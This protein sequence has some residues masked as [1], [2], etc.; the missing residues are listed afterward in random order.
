LNLNARQQYGPHVIVAVGLG[1]LVAPVVLPPLS[2]GDPTFVYRAN[3]VAATGDGVRIEG[4]SLDAPQGTPHPAA[5]DDDR[6]CLSGTSRL[7]AFE[8]FL[9]SGH[10]VLSTYAFDRAP[11]PELNDKFL[12]TGYVYHDGSFYRQTI[13]TR[14]DTPYLSLN[15]TPGPMALR[16]LAVSLDVPPPW[17]EDAIR[18]VRT[19]QVTTHEPLTVLNERVDDGT[20]VAYDDRVFVL[21]T[22]DERASAV[23]WWLSTVAVWASVAVGR[24]LT[25]RGQHRWLTRRRRA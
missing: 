1:F 19:G 11:T 3:E 13:V 6:Y 4:S 21:Y 12:E 16:R 18:A 15:G 23:P 10:E 17:G 7:R 9:L 22:V 20:L 24:A 5:L 14:N 8:Q 2:L 25:L